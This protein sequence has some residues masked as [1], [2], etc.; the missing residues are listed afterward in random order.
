MKEGFVTPQQRYRLVSRKWGRK[1]LFLLSACSPDKDCLRHFREKKKERENDQA[2]FRKRS[3]GPGCS[4]RR[5]LERLGGIGL[6]QWEGKKGSPFRSQYKENKCIMRG[7]GNTGV[8]GYL[9]SLVP[10]Y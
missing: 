2:E 1:H 5:D 10:T 3:C 7:G 9:L 6:R 8:G 4:R